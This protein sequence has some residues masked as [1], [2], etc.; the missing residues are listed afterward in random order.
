MEQGLY[1]Q[2]GML[3]WKYLKITEANKNKNE[4]KFKF[5]GQSE[6]SKRWFDLNFD[7]I[8]ENF[9]TCEP[10]FF[11][12]IFQSHDNPQDTN[13][14]Q[15]FEFPIINSKCVEK[16]SFTVMPQCSS[17]VKSHWIVVVSVV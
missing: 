14:F 4:A 12:K 13:T 5:Q 1:V 2:V 11:G 7:W 8:G 17:I 6:I 9:S 3:C 16:L 10:G 15:M